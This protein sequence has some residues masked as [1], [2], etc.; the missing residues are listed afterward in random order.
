MGS[1]VFDQSAPY[2]EAVETAGIQKPPPLFF[3]QNHLVSR[4]DVVEVLVI[5]VNHHNQNVT[6]RKPFLDCI[7]LPREGVCWY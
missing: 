2:D 4:Q 1:S 5:Q 3:L 6:F 7:Q